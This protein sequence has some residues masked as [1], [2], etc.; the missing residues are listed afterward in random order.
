MKLSKKEMNNQPEKTN[1]ESQNNFKKLI[2]IYDGLIKD[3]ESERTKYKEQIEQMIK[4]IMKCE[5]NIK[6]SQESKHKIKVELQ[7]AKE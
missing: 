4:Y 3:F 2:Y 7:I 5:D 1:D 6:E